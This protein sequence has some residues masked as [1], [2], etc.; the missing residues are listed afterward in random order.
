MKT[1]TRIV[2]LAATVGVVLG[3]LALGGV[4]SGERPRGLTAADFAPQAGV[5]G[6]GDENAALRKLLEGFSTGD[7][8]AFAAALERN[9]ARNAGDVD[10]LTLLGLTYQQRAR[11]T[12]DATYLSLAER[13]LRR[14]Q[15]LRPAGP[16]IATGL[17]TLAVAR[18]RFE[19]AVR[20]ARA[21]IAHNDEDA[22]AYG[23][24]GD[25]LLN[26]G[27]IRE[28]FAAYDRMVLL[29]PGIASYTR[30]SYARELLGRPRA[31]LRTLR[32]TFDLALTVP[33]HT[34][35]AYVA[36][37]N[38]ELSTG[39]V[40]AAERAYRRALAKV[41]GYVYGEAGLARVEAA[42][43]DYDRAIARLRR[44]VDRLPS[45][46]NAILLGDVL[47][48]AGRPAEARRA[49]GLVDAIERLLEA[50]GVRTELQTAL[51]DLDHDR[52]LAG[53]LERAQA[54]YDDAPSL[55]AADTLAWA[56][57]KNGRCGDARARSQEALRLGTQDALMLFH[58]GEIE[59]CLGNE[60][61]A[62]AYLRRALA[63]NP[64]FSLLYER[65]ARELAA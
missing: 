32:D 16:L 65:T 15:R 37:G 59:R 45:P 60:R 24:L 11:E 54:A 47:T 17:A 44:V 53:A 34:A 30:I 64:H 23:A 12:G 4:F 18:H 3:G 2:L 19:D 31:A 21:A 62:R 55:A 46:Q 14:A 58:R 7:T 35:A 42:Q 52:D 63:V 9:V 28:A 25:A 10:S 43:G 48:A 5:A 33:E 51:F 61:A 8:A 49:Y 20:E 27:R 56:L 26:L 22:T 39:D 36:L 40:R 6:V 29:S 1:R 13:A 41:P 57:Y 38:L 50:N